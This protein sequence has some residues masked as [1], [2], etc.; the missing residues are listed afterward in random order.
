MICLQFVNMKYGPHRLP[1]KPVQINEKFDIYI[2]YKIGRVAQ[3]KIF[4]I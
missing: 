1:E 3:E 2:Y 4:K